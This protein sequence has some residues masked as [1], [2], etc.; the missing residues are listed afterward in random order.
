[1]QMISIKKTD[2]NRL[3]I[4]ETNQLEKLQLQGE[5]SLGTILDEHYKKPQKSFP[6]IIAQD[7]NKIIGWCSYMEV[8]GLLDV[9]LTAPDLHVFV[10]ERYRRKGIGRLLVN[11]LISN[12]KNTFTVGYHDELSKK[13]WS[14]VIKEA[15]RRGVL[16]ERVLWND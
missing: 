12:I 2:L 14:S 7:K 10:S 15:P 8:D 3:S 11:A 4:R 6:I 16:S 1:M 9:G 5:S 13:F